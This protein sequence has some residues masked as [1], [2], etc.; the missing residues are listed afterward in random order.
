MTTQAGFDATTGYWD[1][2]GNWNP[3]SVPTANTDVTLGSGVQLVTAAGASDQFADIYATG[4]AGTDADN[5]LEVT[6]TLTGEAGGSGLNLTD[7][8][9]IVA[10]DAAFSEFESSLVSNSLI[11]IYG[12]ATVTDGNGGIGYGGLT[13]STIVVEAGGTLTTPQIDSNNTDT[14]IVDG[15]LN[16]ADGGSNG[17][18]LGGSANTVNA[19]GTVNIAGTE[20]GNWVL[21]GGTYASSNLYAA[22]EFTFTG[23]GGELDLEDAQEYPSQN[24]TIS[25]YA[26]GDVIDFGPSLASGTSISSTVNSSGTLIVHAG[27]ETYEVEHFTLASGNPT[28]N[29]VV[30]LPTS[31]APDGQAQLDGCFYAGTRLATED[32]DIAVEDIAAGTMLKTASGEILPVRWLGRSSVSTRFA[33]PLRALPI[34]IKAGA[35]GENLPVRD[36]LVSPC[37]AMFLGGVLIHAGA[38]VNGSSILREQNVPET[39]T[40]FH[41][42][43]ATHTLLIAEGAAAESFIDNAERMNFLNWAEYEALETAPLEEMPYPRAKAHRQV[44]A[45][46]RRQLAARADAFEEA[47]R[48][49]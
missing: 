16:L 27:N 33:D 7:Y 18:K 29:N 19:G 24:L 2:S 47:M 1:V 39:F 17:D 32:G 41:V 25:G 14:L 23:T 9:F 3:G 31:I 36:L 30:I 26:P 40:Y 37:H 8:T 35:L 48:A 11:E 44:P 42:E 6:G 38:L 5:T 49:A 10:K 22:G 15:V 34:R 21:N 45:A 43:L 20:D 13:N 12:T 46:I 28:G 4:M